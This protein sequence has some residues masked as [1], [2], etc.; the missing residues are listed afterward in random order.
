MGAP[1]KSSLWWGVSPVQWPQNWISNCVK[2]SK[3]IFNLVPWKLSVASRN[4]HMTKI[5]G[6]Q[7]T[8]G[9]SGRRSRRCGA[10]GEEWV[11]DGGV[12]AYSRLGV[13]R[14]GGS[15]GVVPEV[16]GVVVVAPVLAQ[17]VAR[18]HCPH[19]RWP[20]GVVRQPGVKEMLL[21]P[22]NSEETRENFTSKVGFYR[23]MMQIVWELS[24]DAVSYFIGVL[25]K[26]HKG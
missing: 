10:R 20:A 19:H 1:L 2:R 26:T 24:E 11:N 8:T 5:N 4:I 13:A 12:G 21:L 7:R 22:W 16:G 9:W 18:P 3:G 23:T 6:E 25:F 14:Q 15:P 17:R